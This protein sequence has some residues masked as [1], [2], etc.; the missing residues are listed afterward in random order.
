MKLEVFQGTDSSEMEKVVSL[1]EEIKKIAVEFGID[2]IGFGSA[3]RLEGI[4]SA[5]PSYLLPETQTV[6][7]M[8]VAYDRSAVRAFLAKKDQAAF[9][10]DTT[11]SYKRL[12][13]A[14]RA[15]AAMLNERGHESVNVVPNFSYRAQRKPYDMTPDFSH[16]YGAVAAG[17]GCWAGA[18]T[19]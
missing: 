15:I 11:E 19:L 1:K 14:G 4:P 8:V 17:G 9:A 2:K 18:G 7:A 12:F 3:D 16:R 5:D 6:I 13:R 10:M